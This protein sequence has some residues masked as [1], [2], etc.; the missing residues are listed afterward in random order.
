[1]NIIQAI[2]D[3]NLFL[4]FF[5]D[6][7]SW[8]NWLVVLK[9]IFFLEMESDE[10]EV[11]KT[12]S[13]RTSAPI[14][15]FTEVSIIAGRRSGK[16][17]VSSVIAVFVA[18]FFDHTP[19]LKAG[20]KGVVMLI[21]TNKLQAKILKN[22]IA[23][24]LNS[25]P[26]FK[27]MIMKQTEERIE[28]TNSVVIEIHTCSF[29][30]IRGRT[31]VA[32]I[33][34]EIAFWRSE[35]SANPDAEVINALRPSMLTVK[36]PLLLT[37]GSPY[38]KKGVQYDLYFGKDDA[39]VLVF[40]AGS[41]A[42]NPTLSEKILAR[43]QRRDPV[44]FRCEYLAEFRDDISNFLTLDSLNAS[45][46]E[47]VFVR[48]FESKNKYF[49]FCDPSG[50]S[51]DSYTLAIGHQANNKAVL[52]VLLERKPP[53]S[54][55]SVTRE[56]S[57]TLKQY[58]CREVVGDKY[59]G[60]FPRELFRNNNINYCVAPKS[61]SELYLEM[62][63]FLNSGQ[64]SLIDHKK[65]LRQLAGLER[66]TSKTGK[67]QIDHSVGAHD[68]LAN[69]AAGVFYEIMGK[70]KSTIKVISLITGK[71][72]RFDQWDRFNGGF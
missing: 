29:R 24:I 49:G 18:C 9:A 7:E 63:A 15:A 11:F 32:A 14:E 59:A 51:S 62:L 8:E 38:Q 43:E 22:Y 35:E 16:S 21:A 2:R 3:K 70:E 55:E 39:D 1:M 27:S 5:E 67:D 61:R 68:D 37:V 53:F 30:T 56:F 46:S 31:V 57:D 28:L 47:G 52:D 69:A 34:D 54:P 10:L 71:E 64:I 48:P 36:H 6:L 65:L 66:R 4:P 25:S 45:V 60:E 44:N 17:L 12:L 42:M 20:E 19:Y 13:G 23:A 50:G 72:V 33:C 40:Q 58:N 41:K 26:Y